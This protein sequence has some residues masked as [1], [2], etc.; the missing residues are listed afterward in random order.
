MGNKRMIQRN[1]TNKVST[2]KKQKEVIKLW[3]MDWSPNIIHHQKQK[4]IQQQKNRKRHLNQHKLPKGVKLFLEL[5][6]D[7]YTFSAFDELDHD[8]IDTKKQQKEAVDDDKNDD[9][10]FSDDSLDDLEHDDFDDLDSSNDSDLQSENVEN[11]Q[12]TDTMSRRIR[13]KTFEDREHWIKSLGSQK[14]IR[15]F[16][17]HDMEQYHNTKF[18][19]DLC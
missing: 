9:Y 5:E 17:K 12:F 3:D 13:Y 6:D 19:R 11:E 4:E 7:D 10:Q 16:G 15:P 14:K 1:R 2:N 8:E 18:F